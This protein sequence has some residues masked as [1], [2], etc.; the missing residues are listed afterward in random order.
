MKYEE[1]ILT[2]DTIKETITG[3]HRRGDFWPYADNW[4]E[5]KRRKGQA[6]YWRN[7]RV[8]LRKFKEFSGS[9]LPWNRLSVTLLREF[10][11][12]LDETKGNSANT[13][14]A[15]LRVIGTV[16]G[17]AVHDSI[18]HVQDNPFFRFKFP[19]AELPRRV[20]L[21]LDEIARMEALDLSESR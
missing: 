11:L 14:R 2:V 7:C 6:Y 3:G 20:R 15:Y 5:V 4:L 12:F 19:K 13:R 1:A 18:I 16:V 17:D 9:P 10:D 8:A 21:T